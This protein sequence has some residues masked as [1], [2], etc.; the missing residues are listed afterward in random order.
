MPSKGC[1][2]LLMVLLGG[3][4]LPGISHAQRP[5]DSGLTLELLQRI[6][7]LES[8]VRHI[9]GELE[10]QRH[11]VEM[12]QQERAMAG[13]PAQPPAAPAPAAD[14]GVTERPPAG[15]YRQPAPMQPPA[16]S[17]APPATAGR[18][19]PVQPA[20]SGRTAEAGLHLRGTGRQRTGARSAP[21]AGAGLSEYPGGQ[22]RRAEITV[23]ALA[24]QTRLVISADCCNIDSPFGAVSSVGR[25]ADF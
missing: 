15:A 25:A 10:I 17:A 24:A 16:V 18:A 1:S 4:A 19:T 7:Q 9:R 3:L 8:E 23:V 21:E 13:Y 2:C 5:L 14:P 6:E 11:Q 20:A 22:P 12:L